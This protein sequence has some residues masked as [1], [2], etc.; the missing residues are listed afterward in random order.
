MHMLQRAENIMIDRSVYAR[1]Y[2]RPGNAYRRSGRLCTKDVIPTFESTSLRLLTLD[3]SSLFQEV[4]RKAQSRC[5]SLPQVS[6]PM[7][8]RH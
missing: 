4:N 8:R 5:M 2:H 3:I 7:L 6:L 1:G